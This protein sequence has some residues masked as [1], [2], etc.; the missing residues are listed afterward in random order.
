MSLKIWPCLFS[1]KANN[2]R[3]IPDAGDVEIVGADTIAKQSAETLES[4]PVAA[5]D[6]RIVIPR[7]FYSLT[8]DPRVSL[9]K[10]RS[11]NTCRTLSYCCASFESG[12]K[13]FP[14]NS[15]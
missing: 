11:P 6:Q 8:A 1:S 7:M 10:T 9:G 12:S 4:R 3:V 14:D 15:M 13:W 2:V 5:W